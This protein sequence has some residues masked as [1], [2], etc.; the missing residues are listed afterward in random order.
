MD[1]IGYSESGERRERNTLFESDAIGRLM[2]KV[3]YAPLTRVSQAEGE[4]RSC[5]TS[6]RGEFVV[7]EYSYSAS[8]MKAILDDFTL[9][10]QVIYVLGNGFVRD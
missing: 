5:T 8:D 2:A 3:S 9:G 7:L 4:G 10:V 6:K 1:E